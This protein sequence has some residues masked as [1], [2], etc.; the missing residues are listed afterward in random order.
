MRSETLT[1]RGHL[2]DMAR[3]RDKATLS[4]KA[5]LPRPCLRICIFFFLH[6][7]IITRPY[8]AHAAYRQKKLSMP[9]MPSRSRFILRRLMAADFS[10]SADYHCPRWPHASVRYARRRRPLLGSYA[11]RLHSQNNAHECQKGISRLKIPLRGID[12][13][14]AV[15]DVNAYF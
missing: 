4:Q 10:Y 5:D 13:R 6:Y 15:Y 12:L 1:R 2:I 3:F 7:P 11:Y 8:I 14:R 9:M